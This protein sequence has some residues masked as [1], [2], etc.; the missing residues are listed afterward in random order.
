LIDKRRYSNTFD[1]RFFRGSDCDADHF[2]VVAKL[3]ERNSAAI[4]AKQKFHLGKFYLRK[5]DDTEVKEK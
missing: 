5:V 2:L 4:Q 1:V 3:W